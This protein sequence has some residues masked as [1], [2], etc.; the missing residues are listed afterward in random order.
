MATYSLATIARYMR[1]LDICM[2]V[3]QSKRGVLNSRPMSNNGD[4]KYSGHSYFFT[5]EGSQKIKDIEI[6]PQVSLNFEGDN[7]LYISLNGKAKL[8]RNKTAFA[9]HWIPGLEQWFPDGIESEGMV[10]IDVKGR[11]VHYWQKN[12]EGKINL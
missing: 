3:T 10:L 9:E 4:V 5:Y 2:M 11:Q 6:N 1:K 7:G 12:K 8:I